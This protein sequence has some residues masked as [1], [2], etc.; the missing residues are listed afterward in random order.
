MKIK[1]KKKKKLKKV[2][3]KS[4]VLAGVYIL[5]EINKKTQKKWIS[6]FSTK[7]NY[8]GQIQRF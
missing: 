4:K 3:A 1:L 2:N 7:F 8:Q 6:F 5:Y